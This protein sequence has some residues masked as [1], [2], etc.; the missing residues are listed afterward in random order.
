MGKK[1]KGEKEDNKNPACPNCDTK[2]KMSPRNSDVDRD[3]RVLA[4]IF[5][6][7]DCHAW[8]KIPRKE[9]KEQEADRLRKRLADLEK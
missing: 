6:C 2:K 1:E 8:L 4:D 9:T 5:D 7:S 3:G